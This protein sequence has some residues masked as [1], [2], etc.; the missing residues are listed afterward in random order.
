MQVLTSNPT[1]LSAPNA[2]SMNR[3]IEILVAVLVAVAFAD[4]G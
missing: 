1:G 3:A 4:G 2:L